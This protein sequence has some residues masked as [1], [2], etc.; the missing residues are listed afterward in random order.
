MCALDGL[1][2]CHDRVLVTIQ[3]KIPT[4]SVRFSSLFLDNQLL[5]DPPIVLIL[6]YLY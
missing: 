1:S 2:L 4:N 3:F 5:T 6:H